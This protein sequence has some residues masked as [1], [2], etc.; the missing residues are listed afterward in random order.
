[1]VHISAGLVWTHTGIL[2]DLSPEVPELFVV[3]PV[4]ESYW[5]STNTLRS[6]EKDA[7][8]NSGVIARW[9]AYQ[10]ETPASPPFE[11]S[12]CRSEA[13]HR[14]HTPETRRGVTVRLCKHKNPF[15]T[16]DLSCEERE[17]LNFALT[18]FHHPNSCLK[19]SL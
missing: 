7:T 10:N 2:G 16:L 6:G 11:C 3:C 12:Q 17:K 8:T 14:Y 4:N 5:R 19:V 15:R 18:P 9:E 13:G 1:M